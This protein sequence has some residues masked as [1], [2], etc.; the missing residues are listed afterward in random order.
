MDWLSK[1]QN[2]DLISVNRNSDPVMPIELGLEE[3]AI[4]I[5]CAYAPQMLRKRQGRCGKHQEGRDSYRQ[6]NK[7]AKKAVAQPRS[8]Q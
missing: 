3:M 2:E 5:M 8:G 6:A 4:N 7:A 1:E